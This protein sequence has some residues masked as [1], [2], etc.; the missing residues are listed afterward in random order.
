MMPFFV[1]MPSWCRV[2]L[3][4]CHLTLP[5]DVLPVDVLPHLALLG[6]TVG[7]GEGLVAVGLGQHQVARPALLGSVVI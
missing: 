1:M 7:E 2:G 4:S 6:C 3:G 5:V